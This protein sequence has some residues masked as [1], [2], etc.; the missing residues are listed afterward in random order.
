MPNSKCPPT[1]FVM[2]HIVG[3]GRAVHHRPQALSAKP[4]VYDHLW[5]I[6]VSKMA[7][8]VGVVEAWREMVPQGNVPWWEVVPSVWDPKDSP[9]SHIMCTQCTGDANHQ[10]RNTNPT[11]YGSLLNERSKKGK[12]T[13]RAK[14]D[15][16][17]RVEDYDA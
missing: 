17:L 7:P 13:K 5:Y 8:R 15:V 12:Q 10:P 9:P 4:L 3:R 6:V 11:M 2:V 16:T 14:I 1:V